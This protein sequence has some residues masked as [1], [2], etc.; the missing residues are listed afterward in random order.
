MTLQIGQITPDFEQDTSNGSLRLHEWIQGWWCLL[1][2]CPSD[3]TTK[4]HALALAGLAEAALRR[5]QWERRRVRLIGLGNRSSDAQARWAEEFA[6][7]QGIALNFPVIADG[8]RMV[9][10]LYRIATAE[11]GSK[12]DMQEKSHAFVID[13]GRKIRLVRTYPAPLGCDFAGLQSAI[14]DLQRA[15][16]RASRPAGRSAK[17]DA[18]RAGRGATDRPIIYA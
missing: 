9:S 15:D 8:D 2:T 4:A 3:L 10:K 13:A 18:R 1:F 14:D 7:S 12:Q 6:R 11:S 17:G 5:T 16:Q